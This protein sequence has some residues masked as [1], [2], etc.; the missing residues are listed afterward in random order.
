[1]LGGSPASPGVGREGLDPAVYTSK[2]ATNW[3]FDMS[4]WCPDRFGLLSLLELELE[5]LALSIF[6]GA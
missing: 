3:S 1:M 6:A 2:S 4:R 5:V